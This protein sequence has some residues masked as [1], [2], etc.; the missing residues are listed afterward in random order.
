[1]IDDLR[2]RAFVESVLATEA[3]LE[4]DLDKHLFHLLR[5][6]IYKKAVNR[7]LNTL[8]QQVPIE[9]PQVE[10]TQIVEIGGHV[11]TEDTFHASDLRNLADLAMQV[12]SFNQVFDQFEIDLIGKDGK[13]YYY[14]VP[15]LNKDTIK[16]S[17]IAK[18]KKMLT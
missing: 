3:S 8:S 18:V 9:M 4:E 15:Q 12:H 14:A 16:S 11:L 10:A 7:M 6:N 5:Y 13:K 2:N 1:M 17:V